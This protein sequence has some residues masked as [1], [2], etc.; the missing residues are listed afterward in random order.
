MNKLPQV[1]KERLLEFSMTEAYPA[2]KHAITMLV[3]E[4]GESVLKYKVS[5]A[6]P[7]S[8]Q[9][10]VFRKSEYDGAQRLVTELIRLIEG[11]EKTGN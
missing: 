4:F 11:I 10:L 1:V 2:L 7:H 8:P 5:A 3:A 6:S 9:E